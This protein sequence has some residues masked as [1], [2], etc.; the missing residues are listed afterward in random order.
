MALAA[1]LALGW[2]G[3]AGR[4]ADPAMT[5][6]DALA[7]LKK[8]TE[9]SPVPDDPA[10]PREDPAAKDAAAKDAA[11][12]AARA[13]MCATGDTNLIRALCDYQYAHPSAR[14]PLSA[15]VMGTVYWEQPEPFLAVYKG[16]PAGQK[17]KIFPF[18]LYGF[19]AHTAEK[20]K[21]D[22]KFKKLQG[23]LD[24]IGGALVNER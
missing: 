23:Q 21:S 6:E 12:R 4:A 9:Q 19:K 16:L 14:Y 11:F 8:Y 18:L 15:E 13:H 20:N 7:A 10:A 17:R 2:A 5:P 24:R 3:G 22:S 1:A